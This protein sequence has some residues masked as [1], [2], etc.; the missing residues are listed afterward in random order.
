[1]ASIVES[2]C[3]TSP[4]LY[5]GGTFVHDACVI[6]VIKIIDTNHVEVDVWPLHDAKVNMI[7]VEGNIYDFKQFTVPF[8]IYIPTIF[9]STSKFAKFKVCNISIEEPNPLRISAIVVYEVADPKAVIADVLINGEGPGTLS[10]A[11]GD[12]GTTTYAINGAGQYY[13]EK[14]LSN[15]THNICG[16]I[17][18]T[19]ECATIIIKEDPDPD[20]GTC[21]YCTIKELQNIKI[22]EFKPDRQVP[23]GDQY[24]ITVMVHDIS[25]L[26]G[27]YVVLCLH[28]RDTLDL[29]YSSGAVKIGANEYLPFQ[30]TGQM[31]DK[32]LKLKLS[33]IDDNVWPLSDDCEDFKDFTITVGEYKPPIEDEDY[34]MYV[35]LAVIV[36]LG[37]YMIARR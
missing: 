3:T 32:D 22:S 29:I 12:Q 19:Q 13:F 10:I 15:G 4:H 35:G 18:T 28:D 25:V 7:M 37:I 26:Y 24:A 16:S 17:G 11:W 14:S 6:D 21:P 9:Y 8:R 5:A 23:A 1:M 30:I 31:P 20:P 33:V 27:D 36:A 2:N 34:L